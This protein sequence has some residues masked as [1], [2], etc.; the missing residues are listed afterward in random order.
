MANL[1]YKDLLSKKGL[2]STQQR[3]AILEVL[4]QASMPITAEDIYLRLKEKNVST[5]LSTVYRTL[6]TLMSKKIVTKSIVMSENKAKFEISY[7]E[8]R[9]CHRLICLGCTKIVNIEECPIKEF[10]NLVHK[11]TDYDVTGHKIEIYGYCPECKNKD[12]P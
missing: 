3:N 8:G 5:C 1:K 10:E 9:H 6:D 4:E 2:K 12:H 7:E 11:S